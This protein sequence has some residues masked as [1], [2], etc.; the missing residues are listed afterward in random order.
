K[1]LDFASIV[2]LVGERISALFAANS[3]Y[4]AL[5]DPVKRVITFPYE[6]H[7]GRPVQSEPIELGTGLTSIVIE[8][9]RPLL[10]GTVEESAALGAIKDDFD[11]ASWLGVPILAGDRVL[12]VIALESLEP[13]AY[14][15]ADARLLGTVASSMGV[16]LENA[17]LFDETKRLLAESDQRAAE[18]AIINEV[19][20]GL[21]ERLDMQAMYDLV[22]DRIQ[23]TFDSQ[24]VDIG[25]VD[26]DAGLIRF[27]YSI[28]RGVRFP[29]QPIPIGGLRQRV[30]ESGQV[31]LINRD[32]L[33]EAQTHGGAHKTQ[34][35][36]PRSILFAPLMS[37][38]TVVGIISLQ[39]FDRE[40]AF[41]DSDVEL[42]TTLASS[43]SVA[44]ENARLFDETKR[45][46]AES[47]QRAAEL[48]VINEIGAALA[49]QLDFQSI[50]ELVGERVGSIF[51][52]RSLHISFYDET[53]GRIDFPYLIEEGERYET[54]PIT[55][56]E[57]L[58]SHVIRS[59][60]PLKLATSEEAVAMGAI[61]QG[62]TTQSWLGVPI[63]AGDRVL[64]TIALES[65]T[66]HAYDEADVRLLST[67]ASS[68]GQALE[69]ARLFDET[70]RLLA[71]TDERAAELA[72][73]NGV[74]QGLAAQLDM[75]TMYD[76]VGNKVQ[77]I[78]DAQV[79]DIG[80]IDPGDGLI[81]FPYTI[82]RDVRFPDEPQP[83][84]GFRKQVVE[85]REPLLINDHA[86]ERAVAIG[87]PK[88]IQGEQPQS[89]L[90]APLIVG[91]GARGVISLQN[92]DRE[93]AFSEGDVRLLTTL[94]ASLSVAL[95]NARLIHETRQ[96]VAELD[97][98]NRVGQAISSQ[99][100]LSALLDLVGEQMRET[101]GADIVYVALHDPSA[102][103]I[104]FP[105]Y[106]E[107]G[108]PEAQQ[109]L[110][111]GTGLT[112][113][114]LTTREPLLLN[115]SAHFDEVGT[116]GVGTLARSWLGVPILAGDS[117]IGVISVQSTTQEGRFGDADVR[118]LT[119]IAANV[120]AAIQNARL[121]R[122][123]HRRADE[124]AALADV[125]R[126]ISATLDPTAVLERIVEQA[127]VLLGAESSA[128]YLAQPDG[129]SFRAIVA[130]GETTDLILADTITVGEGII[131]DVIARQAAEVV[132]DAHTDSRTVT[133]P[134]TD[135][136]TE[137]RLMAAPLLA[138]GS[139]TGVMAVWRPWS[140][141]RFS[142]TDLDLLVG[143]SQQA[144]IA[145]ENARL[146]R[147]AQAARDAAE[148]ADRAKSTFLAAMSHE[149]RTPMNA[150]IGMSGLM[151]DTELTEEQR[152]YAETI[153]TS[154]DALLTI[155]NDILDFSKIEAGKV[156]LDH[157]PFGFAACI[158]GALDVL[159]PAAA[160][161]HLELVYA[162]DE[163]LP[164]TIVGDEGRL[165]QIVLNLLSNAVKFT[166]HGEVELNVS[167]HP[168]S[169]DDRAGRWS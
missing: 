4:V 21:A 65:L 100:D 41:D 53:S 148:D 10:I 20:R 94:A 136:D 95:E 134:G 90:F 151:L 74:Q 15:E 23:R 149:I 16:A 84:T 167:G 25:V 160:A 106:F 45:L 67:L 117:A 164:R 145:I 76:L 75:Q 127:Q 139:V 158:E 27:P 108:Q 6:R 110:P 19:Q 143:L 36:T 81:H 62:L 99:L 29:D 137:E 48:S 78:F 13:H 105:Y 7:Q 38:S 14:G 109:P 119:T 80:I 58:T 2:E 79:V 135:P 40:E 129:R 121:Y 28:E 124:M 162:I 1:Q 57:G 82:E 64:G 147:E 26:R 120:G 89:I 44:L 30:I 116:R 35:E 17:R 161:K 71:E 114:I 73:I 37:G 130:L 125:G 34:G 141:E 98:I 61:T 85:T 86:L 42:L 72:I 54:D 113:R 83:L 46:L 112:S 68:M 157:R 103:V 153:R 9:G 107:D 102:D 146:F 168:L 163:G 59:R 131:G 88:V 51:E 92:L 142:Q 11:S 50:V 138:H 43:L 152:D 128:V 166:E 97:T 165:R 32:L 144:A 3:M 70:K 56:G 60:T 111:M 22:G 132:N 39:N 31:L 18:L 123:T 69:N 8:S 77:E 55:L 47:D 66:P 156:E 169:G 33:Q 126:E 12:G 140:G 150:I 118:L 24:A 159:A 63:L 155:I 5:F 101:F 87:Q 93:D 154:G 133:I 96:R 115:R 91:D 104:T 122:E 49:R 52:T